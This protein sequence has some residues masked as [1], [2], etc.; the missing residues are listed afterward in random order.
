MWVR[1]LGQ[2]D[3]WRR[4]CQ[5]TPVFLPGKFPTQRSLAA[6]S[7]W[8]QQRVGH[9]WETDA[10]KQSSVEFHR[11]H[12]QTWL[13]ASPLT[14]LSV[15]L[16]TCNVNDTYHAPCM[17][18]PPH[19]TDTD[20]ACRQQASPSL[21]GDSNL[22]TRLVSRLQW[23]GWHYSNLEP[24]CKHSDLTTSGWVGMGW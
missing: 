19:R 11:C 8:G 14:P 15:G 24:V 6:C 13:W 3:P 4:T 5:P 17:I 22:E 12:L 1:S 7:P 10:S 20:E 23:Q 2:E 18:R 21:L 9:D 16:R